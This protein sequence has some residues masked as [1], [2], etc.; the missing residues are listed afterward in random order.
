MWAGFSLH[1]DGRDSYRL[2]ARR[3]ILSRGRQDGHAIESVLRA[4]HELVWHYA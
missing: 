4:E 1:P 2:K 3:A